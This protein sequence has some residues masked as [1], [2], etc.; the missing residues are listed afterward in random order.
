MAQIVNATDA[1]IVLTSDWGKNY[2]INAYKQEDKLCKYLSNKLRKQGLTIYDKID[3]YNFK[4]YY[5]AFAILD[6]LNKH[7][8]VTQYVVID[9]EWFYGYN[10]PRIEEHYIACLSDVDH[11]DEMCGLTDNLTKHAINI[12]EGKEKGY[13][14]DEKAQAYIKEK[15]AE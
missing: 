3:W 14:V 6:W 10:D 11:I 2:K 12:L 5:R 9:D 1:K 4:R 8:N 7:P 13:F 15:S